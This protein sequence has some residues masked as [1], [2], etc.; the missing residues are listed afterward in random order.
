MFRVSLN[1]KKLCLFPTA[2]GLKLRAVHGW[3]HTD[4]R[5][6]GE[7]SALNRTL[8]GSKGA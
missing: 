4:F 2:Q 8:A 6:Q 1:S 5:A 3:D 7:I